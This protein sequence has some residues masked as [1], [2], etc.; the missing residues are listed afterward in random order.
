MLL[1]LV[2][3]KVTTLGAFDESAR[4]WLSDRTS[5]KSFYSAMLSFWVLRGAI[6]NRSRLAFLDAAGTCVFHG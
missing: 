3:A 1:N 6:K 4:H 5:Y 2:A